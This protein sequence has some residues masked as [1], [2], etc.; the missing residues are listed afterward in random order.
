MKNDN[1]IVNFSNKI[2]DELVARF[3]QS[4]SRSE[5]YTVTLTYQSDISYDFKKALKEVILLKLTVDE[6]ENYINMYCSNEV[7]IHVI[8]FSDNLI[9]LQII[10]LPKCF[11][12]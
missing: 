4:N 8:E 5:I 9:R 12:R 7:L 3:L 2:N 6:I 11:K 1:A 10:K